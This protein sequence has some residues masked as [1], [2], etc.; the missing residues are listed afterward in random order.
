M[1]AQSVLDGFNVG[2]V[3]GRIDARSVS[4]HMDRREVVNPGLW[5]V[6]K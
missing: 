1:L 6:D 5:R 4:L 3:G 2:F